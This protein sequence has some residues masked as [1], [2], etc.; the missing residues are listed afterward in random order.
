MIDVF[1][2]ECDHSKAPPGC[3]IPTNADLE[4]H[5]LEPGKCSCGRRN[6]VYVFPDGYIFV[7]IPCTMKE[8]LQEQRMH[9]MD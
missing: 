7:C 4:S 9:E 8:K 1:I 5:F 3:Y 6:T 2:D